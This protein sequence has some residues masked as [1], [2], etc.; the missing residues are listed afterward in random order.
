MTRGA[1]ANSDMEHSSPNYNPSND[2]AYDK[3]AYQNAWEWY[4][5]QHRG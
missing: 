4:G 2:W 3:H 5:R 1:S